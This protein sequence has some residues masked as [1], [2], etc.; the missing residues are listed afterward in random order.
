MAMRILITG[1]SGFIGRHLMDT[2]LKSAS[3]DSN[4]IVITP[5]SAELDLTS[6]NSASFII[7]DF[8]P[9][10]VLHL[11]W[12]RTGTTDY[13]TGDSHQLWANLTFSLV[14]DL[15]QAGVI[16][17]VVGTGLETQNEGAVSP[18]GAA[19][20]DLKSKI[21]S[22]QDPLCR[23]ISL[24]FVFSIFHQ[25]PRL[26]KLCLDNQTLNHP[27]VAHDY[28]E[29]R[30]VANQ[31]VEILYKD[32]PTNSSV[33]SGTRT[34]NKALCEKVQEK[35]NDIPFSDCSCLGIDRETQSSNTSFYTSELL[36]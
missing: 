1:N 33:T 16:N 4:I 25:R 21:T 5:S 18:Y 2:L 17:W 30:D 31:L 34:L 15:R 12:A 32:L 19:K 27:E 22:L 8:Q 14:N 24:P 9:T 11:A 7:R 26:M 35:R 29:I 23:W 10:H 6:E 3:F 13:D 20:I 36:G 28:L